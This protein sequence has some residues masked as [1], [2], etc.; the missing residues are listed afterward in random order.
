M[1]MITQENHNYKIIPGLHSLY[2][3]RYIS[4]FEGLFNKNKEMF[5]KAIS[6]PAKGGIRGFF[7][8]HLNDKLSLDFYLVVSYM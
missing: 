7:I 5:T 2:P 8:T 1:I 6:Y 4:L 3:G